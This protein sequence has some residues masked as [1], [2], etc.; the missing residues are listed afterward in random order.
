[1]SMRAVSLDHG[2]GIGVRFLENV[3]V[4]Y[5]PRDFAVRFWEGT[6]LS[7]SALSHD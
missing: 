2:V 1:M 6:H 7:Q 4:G 5:N 3:T